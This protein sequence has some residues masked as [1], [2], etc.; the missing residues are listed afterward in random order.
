MIRN[1]L[2]FCRNYRTAGIVQRRANSRP[3]HPQQHPRL[4]SPLLDHLVGAGEVCC[5][6]GHV[7]RLGCRKVYDQLEHQLHRAA[8]Q[9]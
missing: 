4:D 9:V 3:E 5:A 6:H 1:S 2:A 7:K 8:P